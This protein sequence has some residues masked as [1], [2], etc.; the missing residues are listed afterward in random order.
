MKLYMWKEPPLALKNAKR[1]D[2]QK[3]GEA[4]DRLTANGRLTTKAV[5]EAARNPRSPLHRHFEWRDT[6]AAEAY[7]RHQARHLIGSLRLVRENNEPAPSPFVTLRLVDGRAYRPVETVERNAEFQAAL[8][9]Q[10]LA[11]LR[12]MRQRYRMLV[13]LMPLIEQAIRVTEDMVG[14]GEGGDA[15]A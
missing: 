5:V 8:L 12:A 1:A 11:D 4:L 6:V 9:K 15:A 10:A 3:I 2:P 7:R 14:E 13:S